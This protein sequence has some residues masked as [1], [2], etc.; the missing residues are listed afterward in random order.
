MSRSRL[1]L[2]F[3]IAAST[4][5][6]AGG[7][8]AASS[9]PAEQA[10]PPT[11]G[12]GA[13]A[14]DQAPVT[15]T[16]PEQSATLQLM[17]QQPSAMNTYE[18]RLIGSTS[19]G[20]NAKLARSFSSTTGTGWAIPGN[21]EICIAIPDPVDG[22][23]EVCNLNEFA[24]KNGLYV[25]LLNPDQNIADIAVLVPDGQQ[26]AAT[27]ADGRIKGLTSTDGVATAHLQGATAV[28][29]TGSGARHT[30][31]IPQDRPKNP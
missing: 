6:I 13:P 3:G 7:A 24:A 18:S 22:F 17:R 16:Q 25:A 15:S 30:Y 14:R 5:A 10:A 1:T 2:A 4:V 28:I 29:L 21:G 12:P 20:K 31:P 9:D 19:F 11:S 23:A 27:F 8:I 26:A